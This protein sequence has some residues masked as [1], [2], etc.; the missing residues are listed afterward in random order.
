REF[1]DY[2][3]NPFVAGV[4]AGAPEKLGVQQAFPKLHELEQRYG[5]LIRG[6][7]LG[8]RERKKEGRVSKQRA[9]MFSFRQGLGTLPERYLELLGDSILFRTRALRIRKDSGR[10]LVDAEEEGQRKNFHADHVIYAGTAHQLPGIS[11]EEVPTSD[12]ETFSTIYHPP[13]SSLSLAFPRNRIEHPLD[14]FGLLVPEAEKR[15][16]L[17][18]L[19]ISTLFPERCPGD[20]VLLTVFIGG[21]RQPEYASLPKQELQELV[22]KELKSM[23]GTNAEP[24]H[25]FHRF[26]EKAIPQYEVGYGKIRSKLDALEASLPGLHFTG[27]YRGGISV[28]DTILHAL[29]LTDLLTGTSN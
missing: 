8:A 7:V 22:L 19:F 1:L 26:W 4:Y 27:N 18:A 21:T 2:A 29:K 13:V 3:I 16:I 11:I 5:S 25:V 15:K 14:G 28:A 6:Q 23:L 10:W 17:G 12:L 24:V 9:P 20:Q